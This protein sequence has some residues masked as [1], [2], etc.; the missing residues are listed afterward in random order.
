AGIST[1]W[2]ADRLVDRDEDVDRTGAG[3]GGGGS[4]LASMVISGTSNDQVASA[5]TVTGGAVA[6]A[7]R[8]SAVSA[9]TSTDGSALAAAASFGAADAGR[10]MVMTRPDDAATIA[11]RRPTVAM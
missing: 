4:G 8:A 10:A 7:A 2:L 3:G 5:G 6:R 9:P 11:E 1:A